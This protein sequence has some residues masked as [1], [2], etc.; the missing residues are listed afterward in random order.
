MTDAGEGG[1]VLTLPRDMDDRLDTEPPSDET[2]RDG[3]APVGKRPLP[4][5]GGF[6]FSIKAGKIKQVGPLTSPVSGEAGPGR[7]LKLRLRFNEVSVRPVHIRAQKAEKFVR[8]E[9][10]KVACAEFLVMSSRLMPSG[11]THSHFKCAKCDWAGHRNSHHAL[12]HIARH[13][14]K[15]DKESK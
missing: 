8:T 4:L 10:G 14:L 3:A 6:K 15:E 5:E 13:L 2:S 7:K 11:R 1:G 9:E 12:V